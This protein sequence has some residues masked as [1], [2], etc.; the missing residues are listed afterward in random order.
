MEVLRS[1]IIVVQVMVLILQMSLS[2]IKAPQIVQVFTK[3]QAQVLQMVQQ[4]V[5]AEL[6]SKREDII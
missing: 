4:L 1:I 2:F 6:L 3:S 5:Q